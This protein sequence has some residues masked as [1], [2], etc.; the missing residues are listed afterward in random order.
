M[1]AAKSAELESEAW[2]DIRT[3]AQTL[4]NI[5]PVSLIRSSFVEASSVVMDFNTL[6]SLD[7]ERLGDS[8]STTFL[9]Q[10]FDR[11]DSMYRSVRRI[12]RNLERFP[13]FVLSDAQQQRQREG[14]VMLEIVR[15]VLDDVVAL[16][17][18][19]RSLASDESRVLLLLQNPNEPRSTGGFAGSFL[20][21]DFVEDRLE[22]DFLDMYSVD[23]LVP[24]HAQLPAPEF[25]HDLSTTISL[26]DANFFP[27]FPT[28][29]KAYQQFFDVAGHTVPSVVVGVNITIAEE[30]LRLLGPVHLDRWGVDVTA[31]NVDLVLQFLLGSQVEGRFGVKIPVLVLMKTLFSSQSLARITQDDFLAFDFEAFWEQKNILAYAS[32]PRL[33]RLFEKWKIDGRVRPLKDADNVL[34][35]DFVSVGANKSEKFVWTKL[36]HNSL[37][38]ANGKVDNTLR[39]KRTHA[40]REDEIESLLGYSSWTPNIQSLLTDDLRWVL[41]D[42]QNRTVLRVYVPRGSTLHFSQNPSGPV[43]QTMS[44]NGRFTV[45]E[46]PLFVSRGES[47]DAEIRYTTTLKRGNYDYRPYNLQV[48]GTP[49]RRKT[50]FLSTISTPDNG[51]FS[52]KTSTIGHPEK[53]IDQQYR[54]LVE[55]DEE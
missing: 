44:F 43:R 17:D 6:R 41:G 26:R 33:Q 24:K 21:L 29:A 47:L 34:Y 23:R 5:Y 16:E 7:V 10:S 2:F 12:E 18:V 19:V 28:S 49:G 20:V 9:W 53:L 46:I 27:D 8:V 54:V 22:W 30:V 4:P 38:H 37:I 50:T 35:F 1:A 13:S 48:F 45:F 55:F 52:A 39:I 11:L 31:H 40:L 25:F 51:R 42:A 3:K 14:L 32:D 15:H 36:E